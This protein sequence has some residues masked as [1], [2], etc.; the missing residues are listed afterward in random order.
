MTWKAYQNV[1]HI[2]GEK[3]TPNRGSRH[4]WVQDRY[5][6]LRL[7]TENVVHR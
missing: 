3:G 4:R 1:S 5:I 6:R 7:A 2:H